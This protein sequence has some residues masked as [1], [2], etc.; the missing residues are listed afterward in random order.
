M[1][2]SR[3]AFLQGAAGF[4]LGSLVTVPGMVQGSGESVGALMS[5]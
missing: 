5:E 2:T 1:A 3:E 4:W